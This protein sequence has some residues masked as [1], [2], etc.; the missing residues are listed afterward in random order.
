[1]PLINVKQPTEK[2]NYCFKLYMIINQNNHDSGFFQ[3]DKT[4]LTGLLGY[5]LEM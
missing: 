3:T 1:M 4:L 2:M 5:T